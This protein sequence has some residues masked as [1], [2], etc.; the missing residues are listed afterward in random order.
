MIPLDPSSDDHTQRCAH[1]QLEVPVS[2]I[3]QVPG[4]GQICAR[5]DEELLADAQAHEADLR[6]E[7]EDDAAVTTRR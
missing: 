3:V 4:I 7:N 1:C 5:C 2:E 6:G